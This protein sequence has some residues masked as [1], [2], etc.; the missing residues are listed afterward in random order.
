MNVLDMPT[1]KDLPPPVV[2]EIDWEAFEY[3]QALLEAARAINDERWAVAYAADRR[4]RDGNA[5]RGVY[6]DHELS[7]R[8]TTWLESY[9]T[10]RG[11]IRIPAREDGIRNEHDQW[12]QVAIATTTEIIHL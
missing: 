3:R 11:Y 4:G 1:W 2:A 5:W 7:Q 9:M 6:P 10:I 12:V 8:S